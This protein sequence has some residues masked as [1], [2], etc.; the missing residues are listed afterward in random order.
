MRQLAA[1][2]VLLLSCLAEAQEPARRAIV[3]QNLAPTP[4]REWMQAVVPF[5][6][7][8]MPDSPALHVEGKPTVWESFGARWPDGSVRQAL[9]MFEA[10]LTRIGEVVLPL[11]DGRGQEAKDFVDALPPCSLT[12]LVKFGDRRFEGKLE[13]VE[14]LTRNRARQVTVLRGRVG[15]SGL[16]AEATIEQFSGQAHAW[17]GIGV[18]FSDPTTPALEI[19][20]D[21][22]ALETGGLAF[23]PRH[24]IPLGMRVEP[25]ERGAKTILLEKLSLGDGQ[26]LRRTGVLVPPLSDGSDDAL[27]IRDDTIRAATV[28]RVVGATSWTGSGAFGPYGVV[29][30]PPPWLATPESQRLAMAQAHAEFVAWSRAQTGDP[31]R[32]PHH[33]SGVAPGAT[34]DQ[35]DFGLCAVEPVAATGLPSFLAE[36]EWSVLQEACRPVHFF[37][38][39]GTPL[40]ARSHPEFVALSGRPHWDQEASPD[41]LGKGY[42]P[43]KFDTHEWV[44]KDSEHWSANY[45]CAWYLLTADPQA[46]LEI[47]NET[48]IWLAANTLDPRLWSSKPGAARAAGRTILAGCWLWLCNPDEELG[49]RLKDRME[50]TMLPNWKGGQWPPEYVRPYDVK[51]PDPRRFPGPEPTWVPWEDA[52]ACSGFGAYR[53]LFGASD[54]R[55]DELIDGLALNLLRHGWLL[56]DDGS[57]AIAYCMKYLDGKPFTKEQSSDDNFVR[58]ASGGFGHWAYG[59]LVLGRNAAL[60]LG[61]AALMKRADDLMAG[62]HRYRERPRDGFWDR[63]SMWMAVR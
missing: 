42:P 59:A 31:F 10:E 9:C 26:G 20:L 53:A 17:F 8:E 44:G 48:Q 14:V 1:C 6:E 15:T 23:V 45:L 13:R 54:P 11:A 55:I 2:V 18:F 36:V 28:C 57:A 61:D 7:G 4:R 34:G 56:R 35:P 43:T 51:G 40:L 63:M 29:P 3:L 38:S 5:A 62:L 30:P 32:A 25:T 46:L 19:Q 27:R 50:Q 12:V 39:D 21:E 49:Q 52:I 60:K 24:Q 41:R 22:I 33:G 37:E 58:W 47:R 16:V